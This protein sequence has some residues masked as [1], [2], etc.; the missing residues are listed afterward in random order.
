MR[1]GRAKT[2]FEQNGGA[3]GTIIAVPPIDS[4]LST[5]IA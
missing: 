4:S 5:K 2:G 1:R 3:H